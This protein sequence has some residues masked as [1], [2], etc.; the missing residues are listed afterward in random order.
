M[1]IVRATLDADTANHTVAN[2]LTR[3]SI[4]SF[5]VEGGTLDTANS[6][7][8]EGQGTIG[9][10]GANELTLEMEYGGT[11][12]AEC[13]VASVGALSSSSLFI[14]ARLSADGSVNSQNGFIR[15]TLGVASSSD[16][17]VPLGFGSIGESSNGD[18]TFEI[19]ATWDAASSS[20]TITIGYSSLELLGFSEDTALPALEEPTAYIFISSKLNQLRYDLRKDV[21]FY[22]PLEH[23]LTFYGYGE[24]TF[25]RASTGTATWRDGAGHTVSINSGRFEYSGD[26]ALGLAINTS[27][28]TLAFTTSNNLGDSNT[29][30]WLRD[31]VFKS[32]PTT[33]NPFTGSTYTGTSGVHI[34]QF[35]KF[36][37]VLTVNEIA[38]VEGVFT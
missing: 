38:A 35:V 3:T 31:G 12:V 16:A 21:Y 23:E 22:A 20:N 33:A 18:Q 34:T 13:T 5:T 6:V 2:T 1:S 14:D 29:L 37:R 15:S 24:V 4:Y 28:E 10:G 25:T 36:N 9:F 32:T 11:V 30:C 27:T 7:I 19:F 17:S 8:Y 26:D